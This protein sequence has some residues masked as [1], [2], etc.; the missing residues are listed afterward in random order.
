MASTEERVSALAKQ[1]LDQERE[2][3]LDRKFE[4]AN[5]S[6]MDAVNFAKSVGTEFGK[7]IP[8]EA[9]SNFTSLRDLVAF[10]DAS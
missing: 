5:I 10:L 2:A 4:D 6:S 3:D 8:A 9:F 7:E 1:F